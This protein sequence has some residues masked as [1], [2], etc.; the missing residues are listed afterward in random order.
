M[1]TAT[2]GG[3][4]TRT[5]MFPIYFGAKVK[6][7]LSRPNGSTAQVHFEELIAAAP[8]ASATRLAVGL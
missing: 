7:E 2:F 3:A 8:L 4:C 1:H 5:V 6:P